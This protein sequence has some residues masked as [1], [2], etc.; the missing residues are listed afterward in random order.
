MIPR[1]QTHDNQAKNSCRWFDDSLKHGRLIKC[2]HEDRSALYVIPES[3]RQFRCEKDSR[4]RLHSIQE[5]TIEIRNEKKTRALSGTVRA[6]D[7]Y[8][9][10]AGILN[11]DLIVAGFV[12]SI[13]LS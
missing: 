2:R 4:K 13:A 10:A 1:H 9:Y 7:V 3:I 12:S 6:I 8:A 5:P 11:E